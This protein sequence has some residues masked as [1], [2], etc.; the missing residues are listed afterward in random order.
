M[1]SAA[2]IGY[3]QAGIVGALISTIAIFLPPG[4]L[5][6]FVNS[7]VDSIK[8]STLLNA[9]LKGIRATAIGMIFAAA[10]IIG[11]GFVLEW[12]PMT[13]FVIALIL[14][15]RFKVSVIYL[16]PFSGLV[17]YFFIGSS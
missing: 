17:G 10:W 2:F 5:M 7:F 14:T 12:I 13:I 8:K 16:I 4:L 1:I 3:K 15:Y 11:K 9:A 6:I